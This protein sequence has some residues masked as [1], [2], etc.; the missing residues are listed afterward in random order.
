MIFFSSIGTIWNVFI[1]DGLL[2]YLFRDGNYAAQMLARSKVLRSIELKHRRRI[3]ISLFFWQKYEVLGRLEERFSFNT[4]W[5]R[6]ATYM[7]ITTRFYSLIIWPS[8]TNKM[9]ILLRDI[10]LMRSFMFLFI[11]LSISFYCFA[12]QWWAYILWN[13]W[14]WTP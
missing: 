8:L 7:C 6:E 3:N 2:K 14:R 4:T 10:I 12:L 13:V 5:N 11:F 9:Y 1:T